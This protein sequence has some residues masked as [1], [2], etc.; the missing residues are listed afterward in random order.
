MLTVEQL[1][2][3]EPEFDCMS[4]E[5]IEA[6]LCELYK[7]AEFAFDLWWD[8]KSGSKNPSGLLQQS[9]M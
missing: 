5:E 6:V 7:S 3:I 8:E 9:K 1:R 2:K 4:D